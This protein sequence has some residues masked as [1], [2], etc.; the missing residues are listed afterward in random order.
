VDA[1]RFQSERITAAVGGADAAAR[2]TPA[3]S[4]ARWERPACRI[5]MQATAFALRT[6]AGTEPRTDRP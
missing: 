6:T 5:N 3:N 1:L 4:N 2:T